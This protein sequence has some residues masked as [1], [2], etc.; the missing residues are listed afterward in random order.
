MPPPGIIINGDTT[1]ITGMTTFGRVSTPNGP[2]DEIVYGLEYINGG[3]RIQYVIVLDPQ[4]TYNA[5][6]VTNGPAAS[7]NN[8][9][10]YALTGA[11]TM[12]NAVDPTGAATGSAELVLAT[13][14]INDAAPIG[15]D[16]HLYMYPDP[17]DLGGSV[18]PYDFAA[19]LPSGQAVG[20]VLGHQN[21]IVIL[22]QNEYL[23]TNASPG[24]VLAGEFEHFYYTD[25]PNTI[26]GNGNPDSLAQNEVFVQEWPL[27]VGCYG[28]ISAGELFCVKHNGGGFIV[29]GDLNN[30]TVTW[31]GGVTPT[32][33]LN[34]TAVSTPIGMVYLSNANGLWAWNGSNTSQKISVQLNDDFYIIP[35]PLPSIGPTYNLVVWAELFM[36]PN[37]YLFDTT[38]GG[39]WKLDN[40]TV[41]FAWYGVAYDGS[42]L[43]AMPSNV[44]QS[45]QPV[46]Y[47]YSQ[48]TPANVYSWKS[49][50]IPKSIDRMVEVQECA[51]RAQGN[52]MVTLTF[53]ADDGSSGPT[54]PASATFSTTTRPVL[55]RQVVATTGYDV[56]VTITST[57]TGGGP[58]PVVYG[59]SVGFLE[60]TPVN[61]T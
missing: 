10:T 22:Q 33:N 54:Q 30:P 21:R 1:W 59:F 38:T 50:P 20:V 45:T 4:G 47:Q 46:V 43:Y 18:A 44:T 42:S 17:Y 52:G 49:Y 31:L 58:A 37:N 26:P 48:D 36:V 61:P 19:D 25:P 5:A 7:V 9:G 56:T 29:S 60:T 57:G 41:P 23:W 34:A 13:A 2:S 14:F 3:N 35:D 40:Q 15:A 51:V 16:S 27:G 32:Y 6:I 24:K 11:L 28:S 12:A 55:Q 8:S 39:W 53:T